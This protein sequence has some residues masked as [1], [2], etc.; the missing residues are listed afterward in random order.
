M[1]ILIACISTGK[2]TWAHV[3]KVIQDQDWSKIILIVNEFAKDFNP[4]KKVE[5]ILVNTNK[6]TTELADE[7]KNQ[8]QNKLKGE[9]EVALN[10]ISGDGKEHMALLSA[11]IKLGIGIRLIVL[12]K[13][14]IK[15]I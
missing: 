13:E 14:G 2:G 11:L 1:T 8:L 9:F 5:K 12:T 3:N 4:T 7:L 15:E 6:T 10:M